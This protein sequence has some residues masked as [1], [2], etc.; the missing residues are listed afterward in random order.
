MIRSSERKSRSIDVFILQSGEIMKHGTRDRS[1][2]TV[3]ISEITRG[4]A[5]NRVINYSREGHL[6]RDLC[7][8]PTS[9]SSLAGCQ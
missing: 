5:E 8:F 2:T 6:G 1:F 4:R 9:S 7:K 3:K